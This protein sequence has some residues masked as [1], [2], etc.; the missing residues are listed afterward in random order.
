MF[1]YKKIET[2]IYY[3]VQYNNRDTKGGERIEKLE[4]LFQ[5]VTWLLMIITMLQNYHKRD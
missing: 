2:F 5:I 1:F 4:I 3:V